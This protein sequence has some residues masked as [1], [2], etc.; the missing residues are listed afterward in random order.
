MI[1]TMPEHQSIRHTLGILGTLAEKK[2]D[3]NVINLVV[4]DWL[5]GS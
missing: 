1:I 4:L 3:G 2:K 5:G